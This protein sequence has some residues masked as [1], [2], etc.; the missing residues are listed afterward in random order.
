MSELLLQEQQEINTFSQHVQKF[1]LNNVPKPNNLDELAIELHRIFAH[2]TINIDYVKKLLE[3]FESN[4]K[5][6][7]K[8]AK[9]D[10]H[11]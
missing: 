11:K 8:Y 7:I 1:D 9:Y 10:P 4:P 2:N 6:W 5:E 3:N